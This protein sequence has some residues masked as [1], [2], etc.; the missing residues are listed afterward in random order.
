M[1][2]V[3]VCRPSSI[4]GDSVES[5]DS[6]P[7]SHEGN[8]AFFTVKGAAVV[9]SH[10][11]APMCSRSSHAGFL[12]EIEIHLQSM[13]RLLRPE[14]TLSMAVRLQSN[15]SD[16]ARYLA[17]VS[18]RDKRRRIRA[19]W[20]RLLQRQSN[21]DRVDDPREPLDLESNWTA[22]AGSSWNIPPFST[23]SSRSPSPRCGTSF[24]P[25]HKEL[26][27]S[28][29][30]TNGLVSSF[31]WL[32]F[33]Q[34]PAFATTDDGLCSQWHVS[35][36][37]E[38]MQN[39]LKASVNYLSDGAVDGSPED[40]A[41]ILCK[42]RQIMQS[43][44]LDEVTSTDI[45]ERL[46]K[47]CNIDLTRWKEFISQS[48]MVILGQLE[49]PTKIFNYLYLGTEWNASNWDELEKN[50]VRYILNVSKEV[51][52]FFPAHYEYLKIFRT[53]DFIKAAKDS[54]QVVL[55]HCKKGISRSSSTVIAY[56]MKEY[57]WPL[58]KALQYVKAKR[59]CITPNSGFM[60]Q[61]KDLRGDAECEQQSPEHD[62]QRVSAELTIS[63][64]PKSDVC[65]FRMPDGNSRNCSLTSKFICSAAPCLP[66]CLSSHY[67]C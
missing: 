64:Q 66:F 11:R 35:L 5:I 28:S 54:N 48:M 19:D 58:E 4:H 2:L 24:R 45:H 61:L 13:L 3:N 29:S 55:V 53:Y 20:L 42:L 41:Y 18:A 67:F 14:D 7:E 23:S 15:S 46:E 63:E 47:E 10:S 50:R 40:E 56:I 31:S 26:S 51:D 36:V 60:D 1:S 39:D 43:V 12:R 38:A 6:D 34:D 16:H 44:D 52:N 27:R 22:T 59:N 32:L 17:V 8:E 57:G 21:L 9:L 65:A 49:K 25:L 37:D 30:P 62:L 33:Y